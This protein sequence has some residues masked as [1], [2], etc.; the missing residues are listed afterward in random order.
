MVLDALAKDIVM[1]WPQTSSRDAVP[2]FTA[3]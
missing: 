3:R 1:V 2:T